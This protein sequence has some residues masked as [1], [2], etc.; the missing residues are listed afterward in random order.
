[1]SETL[2]M[3]ELCS[4]SMVCKYCCSFDR[5]LLDQGWWTFLRLHASTS[6]WK[7]PACTNIN[8]IFAHTYP[9][10]FCYSFSYCF[11]FINKLISVCSKNFLQCHLTTCVPLFHCHCSRRFCGYILNLVLYM[12]EGFS[13]LKCSFIFPILSSWHFMIPFNRYSD[14]FMWKLVTIVHTS[15]ELQ[16]LHCYRNIVYIRYELVSKVNQCFSN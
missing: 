12:Y 16:L 15:C 14:E 13:P 11:L 7:T 2:V 1:M 9:L 6:R 5:Y 3:Y 8:F 4:C 10:L